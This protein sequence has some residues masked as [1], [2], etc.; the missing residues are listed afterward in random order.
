MAE[1]VSNSHKSREEASKKKVEPVVK[2]KAV[3]RN[4]AKRKINDT[5]ISEDL[6]KVK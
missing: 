6:S 4:N 2:G 3:K 5:L 1:Y